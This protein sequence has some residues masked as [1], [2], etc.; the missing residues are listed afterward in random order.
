MSYVAT[1]TPGDI[2]FLNQKTGINLYNISKS[3]RRIEKV[4][5]S[6]LFYT[7]NV[8]LD[9][10]SYKA[11]GH[12]LRDEIAAALIRKDDR[13]VSNIDWDNT[14]I[15]PYFHYIYEESQNYVNVEERILEKTYHIIKDYFDNP[16]KINDLKQNEFSRNILLII[17]EEVEKAYDKYNCVPGNLDILEGVRAYLRAAMQS[18]AIP[19]P[20]FIHSHNS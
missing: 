14:S 5:D 6:I 20:S 13:R 1:T 10:I 12:I 2:L 3:L 19:G 4:L 17:G 7:G 9:K 11:E 16:H 18:L 8:A 15:L